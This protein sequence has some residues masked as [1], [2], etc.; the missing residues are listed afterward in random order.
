LGP[1][2]G[3]SPFYIHCYDLLE[4]LSASVFFLAVP[5]PSALASFPAVLSLSPWQS[6][7][8]HQWNECRAHMVR[9][10]IEPLVFG[11]GFR[12]SLLLFRFDPPPLCARIIVRTMPQNA[13]APDHAEW[14]RRQD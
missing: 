14:Y 8:I 3:I 10:P 12:R 13:C 11:G 6:G 5:F 1:K 2:R 4:I 9:E 7:A